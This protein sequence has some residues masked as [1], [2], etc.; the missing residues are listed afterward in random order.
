MEKKTS[1]LLRAIL[2]DINMSAEMHSVRIIRT[3]IRRG[4]YFYDNSYSFNSAFK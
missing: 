3:T 1:A 4:A 2:V